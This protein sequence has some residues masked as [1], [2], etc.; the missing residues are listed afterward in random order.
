MDKNENLYLVFDGTTRSGDGYRYEVRNPNNLAVN[1]EDYTVAFVGGHAD[2]PGVHTMRSLTDK[3]KIPLEESLTVVRLGE[4][5]A[6]PG[7]ENIQSIDAAGDENFTL[8]VN[9]KDNE[10]AEEAFHETID[11][12]LQDNGKRVGEGKNRR[13]SLPPSF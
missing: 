10:T 13:N 11:I 3:S 8:Y 9:K 1:I 2:D 4:L 7:E 6:R 12:V 5:L